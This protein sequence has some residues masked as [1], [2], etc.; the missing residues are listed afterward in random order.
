MTILS[1]KRIMGW[2]YRQ[3]GQ[4][5]Y[6]K[7]CQNRKNSQGIVLRSSGKVTVENVTADSNGE[8]SI[9]V[10]TYRNVS[11]NDVTA[12]GSVNGRGASINNYR[13]S[14][15]GCVGSGNVSMNESEFNNLCVYD[16]GV[17]DP[18]SWASPETI[19]SGGDNYITSL[20]NK[21]LAVQ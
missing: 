19:P 15:S 1:L 11:V 21:M 14:G 9:Q 12:T 20:Q 4:P 7:I 16:A 17:F 13:D 18:S 6:V 3:R 10:S 5:T 2:P 8:N